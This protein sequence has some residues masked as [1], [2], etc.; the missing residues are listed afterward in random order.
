MP[1]QD[2]KKLEKTPT[3][4]ETRDLLGV[5]ILSVGTWNG[6]GCPTGGCVFTEESLNT[7]VETYEATK[8]T[9]SPPA[10]LGHTDDQ[11][12]LQTDGYP[13]AGWLT[14]IRRE[15]TKLLAD[16][17]K[18]PKVLADLVDVGAYRARSVEIDSNLSIGGTI[19]SLAVTAMA[20]LGEE[21]PAVEGLSDI[22]KLYQSRHLSLGEKTTA[23]VFTSPMT[24][25]KKAVSVAST[26]KASFTLPEG[27][28]YDDLRQHLNSAFCETNPAA[29][30]DSVW[31]SDVYETS[32]IFCLEGRYWQ[33][34][35]TIDAEGEITITGIPTEVER[36]TK[37]APMSGGMGMRYVDQAERLLVDV[38]AFVERT[39]ELASMRAGDGRTLSETHLERLRKAQAALLDTSVRLGRVCVQKPTL[40]RKS[41]IRQALLTAELTMSSVQE[42]R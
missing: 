21:I 18:V 24:S 14:N 32:A 13:A 40:S 9:M 36:V 23:I 11:K 27:V 15:G 2:K 28:S 17:I 38:Q 10:K 5:E 31:V 22:A 42:E 7:L 41:K 3:P 39:E 16:I 19:Y 37:W 33:Q 20:F 35:Y 1:R 29:D 8:D 6:T 30:A 4:L 12:L 25:K 26:Q 34:D